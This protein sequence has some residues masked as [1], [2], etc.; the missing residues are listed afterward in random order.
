LVRGDRF[1]LSG[2]EDSGGVGRERQIIDLL[3]QQLSNRSIAQRLGIRERTV[4]F[5]ISNILRKM[6]ISNRKELQ[7]LS[8]SAVSFCPDWLL[9]RDAA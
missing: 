3:N 7:A 5:H 4:K 2:A 1:I 9:H 8:R 6:N